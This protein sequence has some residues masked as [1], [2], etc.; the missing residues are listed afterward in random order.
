MADELLTLS[1]ELAKAHLSQNPVATDKIT[2]LIR[3][4]HQ[5]LIELNS[6]SASKAPAKQLS[7]EAIGDDDESS[8]GTGEA[9]KFAEVLHEDVS[10]PVFAGLDP[11]LAKRINPKMA[12][13]LDPANQIH[14]TVYSDYLV[15]LEDGQPVKLLRAY[16]KRNFGLTFEEYMDKWNLPDNYPTT[17]PKYLEAK[18]KQARDMG[19]GV[20]V[21][22]GSKGS[23][24]AAEPKSKQRALTY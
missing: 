14:P 17:P 10:D 18:R 16:L 8:P 19:L 11:W 4:I 3:D 20:Q 12:S 9:S 23:A 1:V 6:A 22:I 15:C 7:L 2:T 24:P 5:T 13:R 21:R